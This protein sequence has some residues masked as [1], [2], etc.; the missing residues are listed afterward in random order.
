MIFFD[1][2]NTLINFTSA[3][4]SGLNDVYE[5]FRDKLTID[6]KGF[7]KCWRSVTKTTYQRHLSGE[8]SFSEQQHLRIYELFRLSGNEL[9]V[10]E[11]KNLSEIY[12]NT[13]KKNQKLFPDVIPCLNSLETHSL[14]I[15]S[16]GDTMQQMDKLKYTGIYNYFSVIITSGETGIFKPDRR[17][18]E[19][20]CSE[21]GK[22]PEQCWYIGNNFNIDITPAVRLGMNCLWIDRRKKHIK[23]ELWIDSL[24][25]VSEF[26]K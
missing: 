11:T 25:K 9:S 1:I 19:A 12:L 6:R 16:N 14:G 21:A 7:F 24:M 10:T 4:Q 15:I 2:D 8:L 3:E 22:T 17:I 13:F 18:F 5:R 20:A 23:S 26:I